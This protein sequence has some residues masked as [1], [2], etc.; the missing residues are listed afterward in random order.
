MLSSVHA[1][2]VILV[3]QVTDAIATP[4]VCPA[5]HFLPT[6]LTQEVR[7]EVGFLSDRF[8]PPGIFA[9]YGKRKTWH[10]AGGALPDRA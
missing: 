3:G 5:L 7:L 6:P 8:E 4:L 9:R 2:I 10:L 1:G